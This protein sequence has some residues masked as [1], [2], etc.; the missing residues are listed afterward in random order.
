M[1][2]R[3]P[4]SERQILV[5]ANDRFWP[6]CEAL[7][8]GHYVKFPFMYSCVVANEVRSSFEASISLR[9]CA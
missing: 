9:N 1:N 2:V 5:H 6:L 4:P 3:Y 7:H 8:N